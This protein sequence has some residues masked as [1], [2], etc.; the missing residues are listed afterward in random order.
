MESDDMTE[1]LEDFMRHM[2]KGRKFTSK[3]IKFIADYDRTEE[4]KGNSIETRKLRIRRLF[5]MF[6]TIGKDFKNITEKD[7]DKYIYGIKKRKVTNHTYENYKRD[8]KDFFKDTPIKNAQCLVRGKFEIPKKTSK[9]LVTEEQVM[10]AGSNEDNVQ[11]QAI[12]FVS[13]ETG[14]RPGELFACN[15][16]DYVQIGD[17]SKI[18]LNGK[19]GIRERTLIISDKY[20]KFWMEKH[21]F[22]DDPKKPLFLSLSHRRFQKRMTNWTLGYIVSKIWKNA[23]FTKN[24]T[25]YTYRHSRATYLASFMTEMELRHYFGWTT[26]STMP[27]TYIHLSGKHLDNKYESIVTGKKEKL[28]PQPSILLPKECPNCKESIEPTATYCRRCGYKITQKLE[29]IERDTEIIE[30]FRTPFA[31]AQ[32]IDID[33][34]LSRYKNYK[35]Y[36]RNIQNVMQTFLDCFSKEKELKIQNLLSKLGIID[37]DAADLIGHLISSEVITIEDYT[38]TLKDREKFEQFI[39]TH[40]HF[41]II[42]PWKNSESV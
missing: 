11:H 3:Q 35:D 28:E 9:D 2:K 23:G 18:I 30:M 25:P 27:G 26:D 21:P 36:L 15:V 33:N 12:H 10:Y 22:K 38:V 13:W 1:L 31:K 5:Q 19:T 41:N 8:I 24:I 29:E 40:N 14:C 16:E 6:E 4:M 17:K 7:V 32:G 39:P 20:M 37:D 42:E 34:M